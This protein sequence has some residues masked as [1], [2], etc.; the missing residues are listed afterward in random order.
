MMS[1][2]AHYMRDL[3]AEFVADP[4]SVQMGRASH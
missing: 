4:G 1:A 2:A 3:C